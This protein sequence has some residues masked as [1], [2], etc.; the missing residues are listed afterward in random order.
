[1][2]QSELARRTG[3]SFTT[4]N[5]IAQGHTS[6]VDLATLDALCRVLTVTPCDLLKYVPERG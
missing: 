2:S 1:M 6:R 5:A 4:I 3:V